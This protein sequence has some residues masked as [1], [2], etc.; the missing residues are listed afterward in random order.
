ME[1]LFFER[2]LKAPRDKVWSV[3]TEPAHLSQWYFDFS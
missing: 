3:I 1:K 2:T